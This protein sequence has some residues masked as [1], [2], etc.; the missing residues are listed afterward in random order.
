MEKDL[1]RSRLDFITLLRG[2]AALS[3]TSG[4]LFSLPATPNVHP[5]PLISLVLYPT[6]FGQFSVYLFLTLSGYS[7][8]RSERYRNAK[9]QKYT[10]VG[11]YFKRRLWRITPV[12]YF[13]IIFGILVTCFLRTRILI[14]NSTITVL[15]VFTHFGYISSLNSNWRFQANPALWT[16]AAEMQCYLTLPLIYRC[17]NF[18]STIRV[19]L[20]IFI[21]I[22]I[23]VKVTN[24]RLF[25]L[26]FF[27]L[28]GVIIAEFSLEYKINKKFLKIFLFI[29]LFL[30]FSK[31]ILIYGRLIEML[32]WSIFFM[33]LFLLLE[34][35][36]FRDGRVSTKILKVL[37]SYSYS[38]YACHYPIAIFSWWLVSSHSKSY[39][40]QL[41]LLGLIGIPLIAVGTYITFWGF[42]K[43]SLK[44]VQML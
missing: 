30:V 19:S 36:Q 10:T 43:P 40:P 18:R 31:K 37:G 39:L 15:G 21:F 13:S 34:N 32:L 33:S 20:L 25:D 29:T 9:L 27:F 23:F 22:K 11:T 17:R 1:M 4:H 38:L 28:L 41:L 6:K 14:P 3:V 26:I 8:L 24:L 5:N 16:V 42:E 44:K 12:Y 7:L 35:F 2:L